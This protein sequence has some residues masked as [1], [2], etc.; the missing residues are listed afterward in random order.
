MSCECDDPDDTLSLSIPFGI[1]GAESFLIF[2]DSAEDEELTVKVDED[3]G[4]D[5]AR[6]TAAEAIAVRERGEREQI[7]TSLTADN[8]RGR[9]CNQGSEGS[10][11]WPNLGLTT[12]WTS[13]LVGDS[14][15]RWGDGQEG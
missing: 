6:R 12:R 13:S 10:P 9:R 7:P 11:G 2:A 3:G 1:A 8:L 15:R 4:A 5:P 14:P